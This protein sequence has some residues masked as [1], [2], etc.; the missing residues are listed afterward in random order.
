[1]KRLSILLLVVMV[2]LSSCAINEKKETTK[3]SRSSS[4]QPK[5]LDDD[6]SK[7]LVGKWQVTG[8]G[9]EFLGDE[10][11]DSSELNAEVEAGFQDV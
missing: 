8:C 4:F 2:S 6:W 11:E 7:W 5:P 1:M 3:E 10:L 9:S